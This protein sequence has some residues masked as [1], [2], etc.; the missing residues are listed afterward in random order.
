MHVL[1]SD[2]SGI[3]GPDKRSP[4]RADQGLATHYTLFQKLLRALVQIT[5]LK[6]EIKP[7]LPTRLS[8]AD[9]QNEVI[10]EPW[11]ILH[12]F[13]SRETSFT[14][15]DFQLFSPSSSDQKDKYRRQTCVVTHFV[16]MSVT[17]WLLF[18]L[19]T[20]IWNFDIIF[21]DLSATN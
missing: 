13:P 17:E 6:R 19:W 11:R 4:P 9:G 16:S 21:P 14:I 2:D 20:H 5:C 1:L 15:K 12:Q 18:S 8:G 10:P 7:N 3:T